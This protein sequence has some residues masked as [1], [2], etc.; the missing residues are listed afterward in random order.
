M[1]VA[2]NTRPL[3]FRNE[4]QA[5]SY[6]IGRMTDMIIS[7][8]FVHADGHDFEKN[9][10]EVLLERLNDYE[11]VVTQIR[12]DLRKDNNV[13]LVDEMSRNVDVVDAISS[14]KEQS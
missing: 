2:A 9:G 5:A 14:F 8:G 12:L 6:L 3:Q 7:G 11:E 13:W 10:A 4:A 1:V